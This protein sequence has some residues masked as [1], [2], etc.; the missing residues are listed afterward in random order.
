MEP[1]GTTHVVTLDRPERRNAISHQ[2]MRELADALQAAERDASCRSVII[3][4]APDFF[5]AGRDLKEAAKS[6]PAEREE[7]KAAWRRVTDTIEGLKRPV[8]AAI[9][10]HCLTG[11]LELALACDL[12][13]AGAG[14]SFGITSSRLGTIP[15]FGGTQRLP[16][17][18]GVS[19]ALEILFSAEPIDVEEAY[20]IGLVNRKAAR[21]EALAEAL[22]MVRIYAERAPLSLAT[23]KQV[24]RQGM[25]L[26]LAGALDLEQKL[27]AAL[28][29]TSDRAEGMAAFIEKRKPQFQGR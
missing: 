15:G 24:V 12:R 25:G 16:R 3:T 11:G 18:I 23:M 5:S 26:D 17:L 6:S 21:G 7:A 10:G 27:G 9:E 2:L 14:A 20:R 28:T 29:G 19:R 13:V 1:V 4:G 22:A 8:V